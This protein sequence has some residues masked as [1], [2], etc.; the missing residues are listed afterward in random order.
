MPPQIGQGTPNGS[1]AA[2]AFNRDTVNSA[3]VA[4]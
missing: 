3:A 4:P 2:G 1:A